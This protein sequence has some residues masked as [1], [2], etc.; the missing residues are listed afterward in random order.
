MLKKIYDFIFDNH[1]TII[2]IVFV[3]ISFFILLQNNH[4]A[5]NNIRLVFGDAIITIKRPM[6]NYKNLVSTS[7]EN[8]ILRE[9]L[10]KLN[11]ETANY[12]N[13]DKENNRLRKILN[14]KKRS[15]YELMPAT[16][17]SKG[18]SKNVN[19]ILIDKGKINNIQKNDVIVVPDGLVGKVIAVNNK[20]SLVQLVTDMNFYISAKI[21]PS[22][23]KG[24]LHWYGGK[25][26]IINDIPNSILIKKGDLVVTSGFS[27]IYPPMIT[28][29]VIKEVKN[30]P[31]G[32]TYILKGKLSVDFYKISEILILKK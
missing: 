26:F 1:F 30:S 28:I 29:G 25:E 10:V 31:N 12:K 11:I 4:S 3:I 6:I 22:D 20:T 5:V 7:K 24:I 14:F 32:F 23:A 2:T 27:E 8:Q 16:I 19:T 15:N 13:L 21:L 9:K 18:L 17:L